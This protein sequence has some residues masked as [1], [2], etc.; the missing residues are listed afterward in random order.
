MTTKH[1]AAAVVLA[2]TGALCAAS[3]VMT[4]AEDGPNGEPEADT[5]SSSLARSLDAEPIGE[6]QQPMVSWLSGYH[7]KD[8]TFV[9]VREWDGEDGGGG[10][11]RA[12]T[13]LP[14]DIYKWL[15]LKDHFDCRLDISMAVQSRVD[16]HI[17]THRAAL[18]TAE[19]ATEAVSAQAAS[20]DDWD[21]LG[22]VFCDELQKRMEKM[23]GK[24]YPGYGARVTRWLK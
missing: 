20:R 10:V 7:A 9:V 4:S 1:H 6:A 24:K 15:R 19:I 21:K 2:F 14:F 16:G 17:G 3:C 12:F 13:E 22:V 11:Q 8:F 23:F 18:V 5:G